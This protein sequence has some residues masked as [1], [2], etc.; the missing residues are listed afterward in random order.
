MELNEAEPNRIVGLTEQRSIAPPNEG[1]GRTDTPVSSRSL[2]W[3]QSPW[4]R[5]ALPVSRCC[6]EPESGE[7]ELSDLAMSV[8][9]PA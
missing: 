4:R 2:V 9:A 8:E 5:Q 1:S 7:R 6:Q 3:P